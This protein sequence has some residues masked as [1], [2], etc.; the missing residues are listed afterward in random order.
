M[1]FQGANCEKYKYDKINY[2]LIL[3]VEYTKEKKIDLLDLDIVNSITHPYYF[4]LNRE[5]EGV[6]IL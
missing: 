2:W 4:N 1:A 6:G 5:S 3:N